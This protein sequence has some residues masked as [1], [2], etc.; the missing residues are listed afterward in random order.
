MNDCW[1]LELELE[2]DPTPP[3]LELRD[4]LDELD[5]VVSLLEDE[6]AF[7]AH[8]VPAIRA[9]VMQ[10]REVLSNAFFI[11]LCFSPFCCFYVSFLLCFSVFLHFLFLLL[12]QLAFDPCTYLNLSVIFCF[13]F[14]ILIIL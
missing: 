5:P 1:P 13:Y 7:C 14:F 9:A 8:A 11:R 12:F 10:N 3:A 4:E 6:L 2:L